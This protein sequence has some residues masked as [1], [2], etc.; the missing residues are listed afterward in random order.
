[1]SQDAQSVLII[2]HR[3]QLIEPLQGFIPAAFQTDQD[4]FK[5]GVGQGF[6]GFGFD[7]VGP[8]FNAKVDVAFF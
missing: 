3:G 5:T 7:I 1:L 4:V 2:F 6:D 8:G